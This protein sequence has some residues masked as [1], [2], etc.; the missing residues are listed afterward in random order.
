M[1]DTFFDFVKTLK[2]KAN[3]S[4]MNMN[5]LASNS[6]HTSRDTRHGGQAF[7]SNIRNRSGKESLVVGNEHVQQKNLSPY[8]K[9]M[10]SKLDTTLNT[11]RK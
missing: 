11:L 4:L 7:F 5:D 1:H 6:R 9:S 10:L 3:V 2:R 8:Q